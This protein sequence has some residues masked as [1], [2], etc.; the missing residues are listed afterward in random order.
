MQ[1]AITARDKGAQR[2]RKLQQATYRSTENRDAIVSMQV[3]AE[4]AQTEA[5][6][7]DNNVQ[8]EIDKFEKMKLTDVKK[9]LT[10]FT[11]INLAFHA[12]AMEMYTHAHRQLLNIDIA[13]DLEVRMKS[14][15][16]FFVPTDIFKEF[17][18]AA[19]FHRLHPS[20]RSASETALNNPRRTTAGGLGNNYSGSL[21]ALPDH[22]RDAE[23]GSRYSLP[24]D[25][26]RGYRRGSLEKDDYRSSQTTR[27]GHH[28]PSPRHETGSISAN[29]SKTTK[30]AVLES[31]SS[32]SSD[33]DD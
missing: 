6:R 5:L 8:D 18:A 15:H 20:Q 13:H 3:N 14:M 24:A 23:F 11:L 1:K 26:S 33:S 2:Q 21:S 29:K 7:A 30:A 9:Y 10:D 16:V 22:R 27:G 25:S 4:Y 31:P 32:T 12:R 19:P 17:R 28:N